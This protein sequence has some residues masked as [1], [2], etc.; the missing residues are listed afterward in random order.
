MRVLRYLS[1]S[2][3]IHGG[4]YYGTLLVVIESGV[5]YSVALVRQHTFVLMH[6][7]RGRLIKC[8]LP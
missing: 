4:R 5:L 7:R 6:H 8:S 3:V 2:V 1:S